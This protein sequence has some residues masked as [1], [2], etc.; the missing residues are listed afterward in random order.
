MLKGWHEV[1]RCCAGTAWL[2]GAQSPPVPGQLPAHRRRRGQAL[3][4]FALV[5]PVLLLMTLG[6]VDGARVFT[7][8]V[9]LANAVREAT[10]FASVGT[11]ATDTARVQA[12]LKAD[13][14]AGGLTWAN[15]NPI[16]V[17]CTDTVSPTFSPPT[18]CAVSPTFVRISV[19][20]QVDLLTPLP[21]ISPVTMSVSA[22]SAIVE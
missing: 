9:V 6:V 11:G 14:D 5:L 21:G 3:V 12:R 10:L 16:T 22:T 13:T 1:P 17:E 20:Y 7:A 15:V 2:P 19:G 8:H 18:D 4:E